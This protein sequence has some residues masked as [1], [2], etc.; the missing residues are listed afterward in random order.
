MVAN[1]FGTSFRAEEVMRVEGESSHLHRM[2]LLHY[3]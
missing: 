3:C 2:A 1:P